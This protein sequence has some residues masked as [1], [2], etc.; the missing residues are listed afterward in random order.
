MHAQE[1]EIYLGI[2]LFSVLLAMIITGFTVSYFKQHRKLTREKIKAEIYTSEEERKKIASDLHDDL[3][4]ILAAIKIYVNALSAQSERDQELIRNINKYLDRGIMRVKVIAN[5]LMPNTLR[6]KGLLHALEEYIINIGSYV[7]F[8][9][10]YHLPDMQLSLKSDSELN[11]YRVMQ[12]IITNAIKHS[13]ASRL[14]LSFERRE[15]N[16]L[17]NIADNGVG[18]DYTGHNFVSTGYGISNIKS[19]IEMLDGKYNIYS[20]PGEGIRYTFIIPIQKNSTG[21]H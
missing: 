13:K 5:G 6:R 10:D 2:L 18:F 14:Q 1:S 3:G 21:E 20:R 17:I 7:Q 11:L 8:K 9:V 16:L 15:D 4:P 12:E 19:R